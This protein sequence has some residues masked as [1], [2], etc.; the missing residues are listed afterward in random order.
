MPEKTGKNAGQAPEAGRCRAGRTD[1]TAR[2]IA[3]HF[4]ILPGHLDP[5]PHSSTDSEVLPEDAWIESASAARMDPLPGDDSSAGARV[6]EV[7]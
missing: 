3:L 4:P 7:A 6:T 1:L 2:R 5:R